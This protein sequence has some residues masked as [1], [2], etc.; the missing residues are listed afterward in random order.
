MKY[1]L[2]LFPL[3]FLGSCDSEEPPKNWEEVSRD[4]EVPQEY[5]QDSA[6]VESN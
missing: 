3:L 4:L 1:L 6:G 2:L 5:S